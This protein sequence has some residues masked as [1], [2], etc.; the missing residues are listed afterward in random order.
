MIC[1]PEILCRESSYHMPLNFS[2]FGFTTVQAERAV[3]WVIA[4]LLFLVFAIVGCALA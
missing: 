3:N 1:H 2:S 4:G